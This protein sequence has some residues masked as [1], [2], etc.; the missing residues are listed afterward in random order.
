MSRLRAFAWHAEAKLSV[1]HQAAVVRFTADV[2]QRNRKFCPHRV[3]TGAES[4]H[5]IDAPSS[6]SP[7]L[8]RSG[9]LAR[10]KNRFGPAESGSGQGPIGGSHPT[11]SLQTSEKSVAAVVRYTPAATPHREHACHPH[12]VVTAAVAELGLKIK[13]LGPPGRV[14]S[15]TVGAE[16]QSAQHLALLLVLQFARTALR[17]GRR[18]WCRCPPGADLARCRG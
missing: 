8:R 7:A 14:R 4:P 17:L 5:S 12:E 6:A 18:C 3:V 1:V 11:V 16:C 13:L 15:A 2:A 10:L 9:G